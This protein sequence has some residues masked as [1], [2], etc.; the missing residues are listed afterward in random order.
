MGV[1]S[2]NQTAKASNTAKL[3]FQEQDCVPAT[4]VRLRLSHRDV[5]RTLICFLVVGRDVSKPDATGLDQAHQLAGRLDLGQVI[6]ELHMGRTPADAVWRQHL[7]DGSDVRFRDLR[8]VSIPA[9]G[10]L[11]GV[12]KNNRGVNLVWP[13]VMPSA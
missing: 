8:V 13:M 4:I 1:S 7:S 11:A 6:G 2:G 5:H 3:W 9:D 12:W 10:F